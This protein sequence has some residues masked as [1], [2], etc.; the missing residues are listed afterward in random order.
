MLRSRINPH[1]QRAKVVI[2][3]MFFGAKSYFEVL[4]LARVYIY[5][6]RIRIE[7]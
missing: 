7:D 3:F 2:Y 6:I 4:T 5:G 1:L